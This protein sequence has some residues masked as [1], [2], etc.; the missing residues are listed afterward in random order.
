MENKI[1]IISDGKPANTRV[2]IEDGPDMG[3]VQEVQWECKVGELATCRVQSIFALS[4]LEVLQKN[5]EMVFTLN[6][7]AASELLWECYD[8]LK[9][10]NKFK[11]AAVLAKL[12]N[13]FYGGP[14]IT[15]SDIDYAQATFESYG[16]TEQQ[17]KDA[18]ESAVAIA[19]ATRKHLGNVVEDLIKTVEETEKE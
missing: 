9:N 1:K 10:V 2:F 3:L 13:F 19:K 12:E 7:T 14:E 5:T 4:E 15:Q 11:K 16:L 18:T 8:V 17:V 6:P